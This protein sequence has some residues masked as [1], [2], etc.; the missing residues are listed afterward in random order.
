MRRNRLKL[1]ILSSRTPHCRYE[2]LHYTLALIEQ[3]G[4]RNRH[5]PQ[6]RRIPISDDVT[7]INREVTGCYR[8]DTDPAV[9][10]EETLPDKLNARL[11]EALGRVRLWYDV[12]LDVI[13]HNGAYSD[14]GGRHTYVDMRSDR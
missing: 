10:C 5:P 2:N 4:F 7:K 14:P 6:L 9:E 12:V 1:Y 8:T 11:R 13:P 3:E